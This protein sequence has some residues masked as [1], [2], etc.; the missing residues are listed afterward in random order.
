MP[1]GAWYRAG[2][3]VLVLPAFIATFV[4]LFAACVGDDPT[5]TPTSP[6]ADGG[7]VPGATCD[8]ATPCAGG[9]P[10]V[11]N[12]CCDSP[13][14]GTCEACN[15]AGKEGRCSPL[16]GKPRRGA[17][18]GDQTGACAG[19]CDGTKGASCTY[20]EVACGAGSCAGGSATLPTTCKAGV[21]QKAD[22]QACT[23][24]CLEDGCLG[25]K[26]V[27]GGYY[28][29]CAVLTDKKVRCWGGNDAGQTGDV[30][31]A[32]VPTPQ[33]VSGL[34]NVVQVAATFGSTCALLE[35]KTVKCFGGNGSGQLGIGVVDADKH[36]TPMP[37]VGLTDVVF[38][39][40]SSGGHF[41][42]IT[43]S[44]AIKCWGGNASGQ[45]GDGTITPNKPSPVTVCQ[46]GV[47]PCAASSGAT[48]VVGGDNHTCATFA[49]G[50]VACW[51]GNAG[52]QLARPIAPN[53][54]VPTFIVP[55]LTA[56][57]LTAG[58]RITCAASAGGAKCWGNGG[59][60]GG[61]MTGADSPTPTS[62]CTKA[63]CSTLLTGVTGV[64]TYDES[65][66]AL[67]GGA[68][69]CWGTN[70]G[71][72]LGDGNA[73]SSQSYAAT[74]AIAAGAVSVA[75]GGQANFAIV[76]DRANRD[77]RCWGN[78]GQS[79]CG[80]GTPDAARRTPV[81]PKW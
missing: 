39:A 10:C 57:Y 28:H 74:S 81:A 40:G 25:V 59:L 43:T 47:A 12:F 45:L 1:A 66:C 19:T 52:G 35:D 22:Q 79:Q 33:E 50:K 56:T 31:P 49:G 48:F 72:Q 29:T 51:G 55:D 65:A 80:T 21:C 54:P 60:L 23:L 62:V 27:A 53:N 42:A 46:P 7:T 26:Q 34:S 9:A 44:G 70:T 63:D 5:F 41:C 4:T 77:L 16:Q 30:S 61:G 3:R 73:S 24:G 13:C 8:G 78:E 64:T 58:N 75:S 20:P 32:I 6:A 37:V 11:D 76:V 2:M 67:A 68:V 18:D 36:A 38:L 71:G 15:L 69:K 17:C 14:T